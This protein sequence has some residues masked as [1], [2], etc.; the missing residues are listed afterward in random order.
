MVYGVDR[1]GKARLRLVRLGNALDDGSRVVLSGISV[2]DLLVD[3]PPP[4]LRAGTQITS[5]AR[6]ETVQNAQ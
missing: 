5:P 4:G 2:G 1:E 3:R 6:P